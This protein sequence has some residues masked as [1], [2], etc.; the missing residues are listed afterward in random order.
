M[1]LITLTAEYACIGIF[2]LMR[3]TEVLLMRGNRA[4]N[5]PSLYLDQ[6][7]EVSSFINFWPG[8]GLM[9]CWDT[10]VIR[11]EMHPAALLSVL[12]PRQSVM[13]CQYCFYLNSH[14]L[15]EHMFQYMSCTEFHFPLGWDTCCMTSTLLDIEL[16]LFIRI[17][18]F[19]VF[20]ILR[21]T[22][23]KI[24]L[25]SVTKSC[26]WVNSAWTR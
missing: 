5:L 21:K 4:C 7:G 10:L 6:H 13:A 23:R 14:K 17:L 3:S 15:C 2:L 9:L 18:L 24:M 16:G 26:T 22:C 25:C 11:V 12:N 1:T 19:S 8:L 20:L